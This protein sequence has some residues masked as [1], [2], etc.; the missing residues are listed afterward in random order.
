MGWTYSDGAREQ[1][2]WMLNRKPLIQIQIQH[3]GPGYGYL[4]A[5]RCFFRP[6][7]SCPIVARTCGSLS[8][9]RH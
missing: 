5:R 6:S 8:L 2:S 4:L 1:K 3:H 7:K 9:Y